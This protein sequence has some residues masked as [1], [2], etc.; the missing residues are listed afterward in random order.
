MVGS[1]T[2]TTCHRA[3]WLA[4]TPI[5]PVEPEFTK[6]LGTKGKDTGNPTTNAPA[7]IHVHVNCKVVER[8]VKG[9]SEDKEF[10]TVI[11]RTQEERLQDLK[12]HTYHPADNRLLYFE[13]ANGNIRLCVPN[14]ERSFL[15]QEVHDLAHETAHTGWEH[16]LALLRVRY[17]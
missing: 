4:K 8:F 11:K 10:A 13:D 2:V 12:Y 6:G 15:I 16:T 17:Y 9:Y 7:T 1:G 14:S 5:A 3:R